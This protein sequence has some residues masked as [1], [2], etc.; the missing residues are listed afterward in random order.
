MRTAVHGGGKRREVSR[1]V[2]YSNAVFE[3]ENATASHVI[4]SADY[5]HLVAARSLSLG[6]GFAGL[7]R[8]HSEDG[9]ACGKR[10]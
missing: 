1:R 7:R 10:Q 5:R 4:F 8:E 3:S 9:R 6:T 2:N